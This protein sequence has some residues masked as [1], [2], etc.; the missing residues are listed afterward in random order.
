MKLIIGNKN[1]S[2]WSLRAWLLM[3]H[4]NVDCSEQYIRLFSDNMKEQMTEFC[5]NYKVP[6]LIDENKNELGHTKVIKIWDS[7]AICEYVNEQYLDGKAW[8]ESIAQRAIARSICAEMHAGFFN[9]RQ[10]LPMN[11]RRTPA[12]IVY[13][14]ETQQEINRIIALLQECLLTRYQTSEGFL[15]GKFSI[16]DAYYMPVVS[17]FTSYQI[18][19]PDDIKQYMELMLTLPAYQ[20]WQALAEQEVEV[21]ESG[22]V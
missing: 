10:E 21:I 12:T 7:L 15:F 22:E 11:C 6:V 3:R 13:S 9:F 4:F 2:S 18:V 14:L 20:Q 8:P 16:A 1:Y 19:V 17:R 5:P